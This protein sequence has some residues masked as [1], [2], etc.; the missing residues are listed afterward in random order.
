MGGRGSGSCKSVLS[1]KPIS[2]IPSRVIDDK[3]GYAL[4]N[5]SRS[6]FCLKGDFGFLFAFT[7][8]LRAKYCHAII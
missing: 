4:A 8:Q 5:I 2:G 1:C 6:Y 3:R 7:L